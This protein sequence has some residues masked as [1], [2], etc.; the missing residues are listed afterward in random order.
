MQEESAADQR[1]VGQPDLALQSHRQEHAQGKTNQ[2]QADKQLAFAGTIRE[3][4][5]QEHAGNGANVGQNGEH[6]NL[7]HAAVSQFFEDGGQPQGVTVNPGL[8]EEVQ[9]DKLPHGFIGKHRAE[10]GVFH[11][12]AGNGPLL[13]GQRFH[14]IILFG[15]GDPARFLWAVINGIGPQQQDNH[16]E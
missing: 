15:I 6:P 2:W 14:Q 12:G 4:R 10:R 9:C 8:I 16:R 1:G 5:E 13:G 3:R 7:A 11:L